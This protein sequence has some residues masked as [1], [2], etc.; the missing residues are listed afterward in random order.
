M[1]H[2]ICTSVTMAQDSLKQTLGKDNNV[3]Y[4]QH[5]RHEAG[6]SKLQNGT[7]VRR[8]KNVK[9]ALVIVCLNK[10]ALPNTQKYSTAKISI[11]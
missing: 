10:H 8:L 4:V 3:Q 11:L 5:C 1:Q 2:S 7:M 6:T 9:P